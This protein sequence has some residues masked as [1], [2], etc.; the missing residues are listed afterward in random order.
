VDWA[1]N[2]GSRQGAK[3]A[4]EKIFPLRAWRLGETNQTKKTTN[5]E[6]D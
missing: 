2:I 5:Y 6:T 4:K 3:N 1:E